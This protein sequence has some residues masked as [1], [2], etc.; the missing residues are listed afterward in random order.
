MAWEFLWP[1]G[2]AALRNVAGWAENAFED[3]QVSRYEWSQLATTV[4]RVGVTSVGLSYGMDI[5]LP[6]SAGIASVLDYFG[7]WAHSAF[8]KK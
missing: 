2:A 3:G 4:L 8:G 1:F 5:E 6:A 7:T